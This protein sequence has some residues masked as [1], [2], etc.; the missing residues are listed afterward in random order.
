MENNVNE[1]D[2]AADGAHGDGTEQKM[3]KKNIKCFEVYF[4]LFL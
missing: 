4:C 3:Q 2:D 1:A